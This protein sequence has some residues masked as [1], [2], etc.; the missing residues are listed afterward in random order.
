VKDI[1]SFSRGHTRN[2]YNT[3]MATANALSQLTEMKLPSG[4]EAPTQSGKQEPKNDEGEE[5]VSS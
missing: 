2:I 4:F 3:A 1:W 5:K